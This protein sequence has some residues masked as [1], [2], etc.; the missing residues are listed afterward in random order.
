MKSEIFLAGLVSL[1][2]VLVSAT[3]GLSE[4][5]HSIPLSVYS[6]NCPKYVNLYAKANR[7]EGGGRW[8][9]VAN[10][11]QIARPAKLV[12]RKRKSVV[13]RAPLEKAY[14]YCR[15]VAT[16]KSG[17]LNFYSFDFQKGQVTFRITLPKD[18]S[19]NPS[20]ITQ[21]RVVKGLPSVRWSIAD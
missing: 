8:T 5:S 4:S 7:Y 20:E 19:A 6:G 16:S 9:V 17:E 18:T 13:F 12:S 21:A 3:P 2:S 1:T 14:R 10:I 11:G 15:A